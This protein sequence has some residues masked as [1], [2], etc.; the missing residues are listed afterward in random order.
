MNTIKV[1]PEEKLIEY[2]YGKN[3]LDILQ[4]NGII[5]ESPCGGKGTC[6]K[7]RVKILSGKV[8]EIT[9]EEKKRLKKEE[10]EKGI[11]LSC[12]VIPEDE[13][14]IE[15]L[16]IKGKKHKILSEGY[17][18]NF[19]FNPTIRKELVSLKKPTLENNIS[20]EEL[21]EDTLGKK[22]E[23][24]DIRFLQE[25]SDAFIEDKATIVYSG[26]EI[27][28][29][30]GGDT[31]DK[32]YGAAVDIGTTTVVLSLIDL[33]TGNEVGA[34]TSINPQKEYGL[35]VLSRIEFVK[36]KEN[37]REI[38]HKAIVD[39][40][41]ELLESLCNSNNINIENVYEICIGANA[42][43]MHLLLDIDTRAIGKSP[44]ATVFTREKYLYGREIGLKG[45]KFSKLYC[46]PGVSSYIGADI[47][48]GAVVAGL[49]HTERNVL[50]I[51]IGTNGEII[52]S[53]KGELT[54][55]SCAAGPAL[56]GA[57]ISCGMRAAEGAIEGIQIN[58][59]EGTV[60][61]QVIADEKPV[62]ICGSGILESIAEIWRNG[63]IGK[64][65]RIKKSED[66]EKEGHLDISKRIIEEDKKR[67]F[68]ILEG[69]E[70][71][72]ITQEDI[73]QV[74]LAKGAIS[75]GF[76]ALLDLMEITMDDLEKVVIA[77]QFGKHLKI[78][79]LTGTG[80]IPEQLKDKIEY[81]GNSS[82]TGAL[83]C[84]LSKEVREEMEQT[85]K[86]I[87]YFELSTKEGYE[88][89]FTKCLTF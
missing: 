12:L 9:E 15:L 52:L 30:E 37:G 36:R 73:R 50:F 76:Y 65:G 6:G 42:T 7:C 22:I 74:Q 57:N 47:V 62:G 66:L 45:S 78:S 55:C 85:A 21:L 69:E 27:I 11:R 84:L 41:N 18:P 88:K 10:I 64:S 51:D 83:M 39:C 25:L 54:S 71:I 75:S 1:Y 4:D 48:A 23:L 68:V 24:Q 86:D 8:N 17:V 20:Y 82:K 32:S 70:P 38:L 16:N 34:E 13:I 28:G 14:E 40:L 35:D 31:R 49:K 3:L 44:Y 61:L 2:T 43:M 67:K 79:S 72:V 89:L 19:K 81:I 77:G 60:T 46:L 87:R 63:I 58:K 59:E 53:K 26:E 33:T 5:L 56:E 29:V 80:I